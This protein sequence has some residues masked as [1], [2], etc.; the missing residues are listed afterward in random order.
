MGKT[1][2]SFNNTNYSIGESS[3]SAATAALK[4]HLSTVMNGTGAT[5]TLDGI[6]YNIDATK[7]TAA[8][9]SFAAY[10]DTIGGGDEPIVAAAGLYETGSN[11]TVMKKSWQELL[12]EGVVHVENG[13]VYTN[14]DMETWEENSSSSALAG[15]LMLPDDG[16][17]TQLGNYYYDEET[18]EESGCMAFIMCTELTGIVI[19]DSVTTIGEGAFEDCTGLKSVTIGNSVTTMGNGAFG[20]CYSLTSVT[21]PTSVT[22]IGS[23]AFEECTRLASINFEGTVEQWNAIEKS[24]SW[25]YKVPATEVVCSNGTV[26]L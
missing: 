10:L 3:L 25:N 7:L 4:S 22:T 18:E 24:T 16:S 13:A 23:S 20:Y 11:Y 17:V 2:I 6:T 15:D 9:D 21:I 5:V 8:E 19:P 14:L 26:S 12:D 1:N